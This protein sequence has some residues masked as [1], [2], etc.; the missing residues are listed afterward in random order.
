MGFLWS[1]L[2][3]VFFGCYVLLAAAAVISDIKGNYTFMRDL[4]TFIVS[5]PGWLILRLFGCDPE[6]VLLPAM[7]ITAVLA[8]LSGAAIQLALS[9][10]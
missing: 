1:W 3:A 4:G 2:G 8:Y 6:Q 10:M 9:E 5:T 7:C